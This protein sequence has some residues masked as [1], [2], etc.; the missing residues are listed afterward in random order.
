QDFNIDPLGFWR[1][2]DAE[3]RQGITEIRH[4]ENYFR[5]WDALRERHPNML[6]DSCASGGRRND[7]E[8]LRRAVPLLRSDYTEIRPFDACG[9]QAH[10][11]VLPLWM[12]YFGTGYLPPGTDSY[13]LRTTFSPSWTAAWEVRDNNLPYEQMRKFIGQWKEYGQYYFGDYYTLTP[14]SLERSAWIGWQFH[15][16]E[17]DAGTVQMFRR[18]ESPFD[19]GHF[20]LF[21]LDKSKT[22]RITNI[23]DA[24]DTMQATGEELMNKGIHITIPD[25]AATGFYLYEKVNIL[26]NAN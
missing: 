3:N 18:D 6:I 8:T 13:G 11:Y 7:L 17:K 14:Y 12:P 15:D 22:Y 1:A 24:N 2:N 20:P 23:D 9:N 19:S 16:P 26:P 4:V 25:R 10:A 21:G 5:Y